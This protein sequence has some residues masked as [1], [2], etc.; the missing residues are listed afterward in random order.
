MKS[1]LSMSL[2]GFVH[3]KPSPVPIQPARFLKSLLKIWRPPMSSNGLSGPLKL[4]LAVSGGADSMALATLCHQI[5]KLG[6][7]HLSGLSDIRLQVFIV[8]HKARTESTREAMQVVKFLDKYLGLSKESELK[9]R[10]LPLKWPPGAVPSELPDFETEARRLRYQ[11][12]GIA[13]YEAKIP[14][15]LLGHHRADGNETVLMRLVSGYRGEGLRGISEE[16]EIPYCK[17]V[18]GAS[19]SGGRDYVV[20]REENQLVK[21][22]DTNVREEILEPVEVYREQGFEY[23]GVKICRPLMDYS[24]QELEATLEEAGIPWVTDPTNHDP[25]L[26]IRNTIRYLMQRRLLPKA[27]DSGSHQ[28]PSALTMA[29]SN[30]RRNYQ[31][32]NEQAALSYQACDIISFDARSGHFQVRIPNSPVHSDPEFHLLPGYQQLTEME[33]IGARLVRMLFNI[34][35]PRNDISLQTLKVATWAMFGNLQKDSPPGSRPVGVTGP[36]PS[37]CTAGGVLYERIEKPSEDTPLPGVQPVLLDPDHIWCLTRESYNKQLAEP[38]CIVPPTTPNER[39]PAA[40]RV[41]GIT[42]DSQISTRAKQR[43]RKTGV[44]QTAFHEPEWQLWDGR[45]WIQVLNPTDTILKICPLSPDRL[46]RVVTGGDK[47]LPR[48]KKALRSLGPP[49]VRYTLPAIVDG[50]DRVLALPTVDFVSPTFRALAE[51][52]R[53][54]WR[55]RYKRVVFPKMVRE[56]SEVREGSGGTGEVFEN[57]EEKELAEPKGTRGILVWMSQL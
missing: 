32:R 33:H 49:H 7:A 17:G 40:T 9:T 36:R 4:A 53:P 12:L 25:K 26:S 45:Y 41:S 42:A 20:T 29:A 6:D 54:R 57:G 55:V 22:Q 56:E 27:L 2:D 39:S 18:Y 11:A 37:K 30:I 44:N 16:R 23:G 19:Q 43:R 38:T 1:G 31:R 14:T 47:L 3:S 46:L 48:L 28:V 35:S 13:C 24:K 50:E 21:A 52:R 34:V 15:L 51:D 5:R 8:D 10:I